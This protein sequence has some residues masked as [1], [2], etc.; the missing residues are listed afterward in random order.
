MMPLRKPA[1]RR[2][3]SLHASLVVLFASTASLADERILSYFSDIEIHADR[4]MT[5][6]ETIRVNA[7]GNQIRR[8]IYRDFPTTYRDEYGNRFVVDFEAVDVERNGNPEPW[9]VDRRI[10]GARV[11][12]GDRDV[13]IEPG[14]H[15][16]R[17]EYRTDWQLGFFDL[18]DEL[19]WNVNGNGWGFPIDEIGARIRLPESVGAENLTI[20]GWV[21]E[22]G[23]REASVRVAIED[24][25]T[26]RIDAT[27]PLAPRENLS[28]ALSW[29]RGIIAPPTSGERFVRLLGNNRGLLVALLTLIVSACYWL[30]VWSAVGRDPARGT[31]FPHYEPPP[32]V[33]PATARYLLRMG[34]DQKAFSAAVINL[35]VKGW[36]EIDEDDGDY[37][38]RRAEGDGEALAPGEAAILDKL[39]TTGR[40]LALDTDNHATLLAAMSAHRKSLKRDNYRVHFATNG[41]YTLPALLILGIGLFAIFA[42]RGATPAAIAGAVLTFILIPVFAWLMRAH[43]PAGRRLLDRIE[44]FKLFLDVAERDELNLRHP[45]EITPTLFEAFLPYALALG[46]EQRWAERFNA[47]LTPEQAQTYRPAWYHGHWDVSSGRFGRN[48]GATTAAVAGAVTSSIAAAA[49]PPGSS[50]GSGGGGFS[51]GGGGGGGGGGW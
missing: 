29:P 7:E 30:G 33:S 4:S 19:W 2:L 6:V 16:Y 1:W 48:I 44:G 8:G 25:A 39:F 21:G 9:F 11:Y 12:V 47:Q 10:N 20:E 18:R 24:G 50:S 41:I 3:R 28:F 27:R 23:S 42:I 14:E 38:L 51:G 13:L 17:I 35:A 46:V 34:Y 31:I 40:V 45:P 32:K 5:V 36:I 37:S 15:E 43:T 49:T 26:A 22:Y